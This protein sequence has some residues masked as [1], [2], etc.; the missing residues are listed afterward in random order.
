MKKIENTLSTIASLHG[1][2]SLSSN[3]IGDNKRMFVM[4]ERSLM[5]NGKWQNYRRT[6]QS[7]YNMIANPE[8]NDISI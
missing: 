5:K 2:V 3:Q 1:L 4:L 6:R 8:I 7:S